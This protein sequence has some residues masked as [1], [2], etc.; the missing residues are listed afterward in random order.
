MRVKLLELPVYPTLCLAA[1]WEDL[2]TQL[3]EQTTP[4]QLK[5]CPTQNSQLNNT[6]PP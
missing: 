3:E 5:T 2:A 4:K 1:E 6:R